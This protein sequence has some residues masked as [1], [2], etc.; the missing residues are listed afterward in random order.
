MLKKGDKVKL[1]QDP[2]TEKE[3]EDDATIV[4]VFRQSPMPLELEGD[5]QLVYAK[6]TFDND[7][8]DRN[9]KKTVYQRWVQEST[10]E[11]P[12]EEQQQAEAEA[13]SEDADVEMFGEHNP[14][15]GDVGCK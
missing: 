4:R 2:I 15:V 9:G 5:K 13:A 7:E 8:V 6:V 12:T 14:D 10:K 3:F 1:F 11:E